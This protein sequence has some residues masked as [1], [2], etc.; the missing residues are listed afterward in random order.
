MKGVL[1][2]SEVTTFMVDWAAFLDDVSY[3]DPEVASVRGYGSVLLPVGLPSALCLPDAAFLAECETVR[4]RFRSSGTLR[5][6]DEV[7]TTSSVSARGLRTTF[8]AHGFVAEELIESADSPPLPVPT[9]DERPA[10]RTSAAVDRTRLRALAWGL[11]DMLPHEHGARFVRWGG[12]S[13]PTRLLTSAVLIP[14]LLA[15][16]VLGYDP[17]TARHGVAVETIATVLPAKPYARLTVHSHDNVRA[18]VAGHGGVVASVTAR[19]GPGTGPEIDGVGVN[20]AR[21]I[22][23]PAG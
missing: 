7:L 15:S 1:T 19:R 20:T 21:C 11:N 16:Y 14:T 23:V 10:F 17:I 12:E 3:Q 22:S 5:A 4:R 9:G 18:T 8:E 6:G 13:E 2:I